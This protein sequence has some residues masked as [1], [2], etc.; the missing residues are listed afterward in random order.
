MDIKDTVAV[1]T[2]GGSGLGLA[3]ARHLTSL[4]ARVG[5]VDLPTPSA[6]E[7]VAALGPA[8]AFFAAD[9]TDSEQLEAAVGGAAALGPL[10][11]AVACAGI[12]TAR[13]ILGRDG[14]P[15]PLA[16]FRRVVDVNLVGTFN[17]I[18]LA[19]AR[20]A[21]NEAVDG[22]RGVIVCTASIAAYEGQ[23]GQAAYAASKA[24]VAGL[25]LCAARDLADRQIRV[26]SIA[27]GLFETPMLAGLPEAAR[28]ALGGQLPHPS[29]LGRPDEYARLVAHAIDVPML[30]G[31][32]IRLDAALRLGPR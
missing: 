11:V 30:N 17:L 12:A 32:V 24:G 15:L 22:E 21:G 26:L 29:R 10:R 13:R 6:R 1:V 31:E 18:R 2:G 20:M 9:V 14:T 27:P 16:E 4:G 7:A 5:V 25:T 19:A 23:V 28:E 3:T 8:A